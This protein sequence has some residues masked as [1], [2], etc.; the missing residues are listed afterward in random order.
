MSST[1]SSNAKEEFDAERRTQPRYPVSLEAK[2]HSLS[3]SS[4]T[5]RLTDLSIG[6]CYVTTILSVELGET[7]Q[8]DI[9]LPTGKS[10][11]ISGIV[12]FHD[13]H[14]GFGVKFNLNEQQ[15]EFLQDLIEYARQDS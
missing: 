6:G 5:A 13:S 3:V 4:K 7:V 1:N 12:A 11:S 10:F 14:L 8:L 9:L 2:L 15:R